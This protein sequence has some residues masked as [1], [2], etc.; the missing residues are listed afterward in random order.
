MS[1]Q[2]NSRMNLNLFKFTHVAFWVILL[3]ID[4]VNCKGN[5]N[6]KL[7]IEIE[8]NYY[9]LNNRYISDKCFWWRIR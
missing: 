3:I 6:L 5:L 7:K 1:I 2:L 4:Y 9:Q 8:I